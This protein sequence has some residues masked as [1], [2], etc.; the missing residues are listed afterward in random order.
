MRTALVILVAVGLLA[1]VATYYTTFVGPNQL[2]IL[3]SFEA[4]LMV[5]LGGPGTLFGPALGA[6]IITFAKNIISSY[7]QHWSLVVGIIYVLVIAF[8]PK[9]IGNLIR[10][11]LRKRGQP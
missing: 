4:L 3:Y 7:T 6:A 2:H 5:I 9:G 8:F 1:G 11:Y 10:T